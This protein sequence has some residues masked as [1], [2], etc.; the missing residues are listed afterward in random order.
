MFEH[1]PSEPEWRSWTW[2]FLCSLSIFASIPLAR[3]VEAWLREH[4]GQKVFGW[5]VIGVVLTST[6]VV[7]ISVVRARLPLQRRRGA[8]AWLIGIA[9]VFIG[10]TAALWSN[11]E[12]AMH[13]VQYGALGILLHRAFA[14]RLSDRS[15]HFVATISGALVGCLDEAIQWITPMRYFGMRDVGLNGYA[16][17][18]VQLAIAKGIDPAWIEPSF[19]E[20]SQRGAR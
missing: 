13:F 11:P 1:R 18:L 10:S 5:F 20:L 4:V 12:E 19:S 14:H 9:L 16:S 17:V 15:I 7:I 6:V 8:L 3:S 2:V